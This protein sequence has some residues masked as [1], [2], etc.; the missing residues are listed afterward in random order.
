MSKSCLKLSVRLRMLGLC[1]WWDISALDDYAGVEQLN[2]VSNKSLTVRQC[3]Q[4]FNS[5][6]TIM[7]WNISSI[8]QS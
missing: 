7:C 2:T 6:I 4:L 5:N 3:V 1:Y 8:T